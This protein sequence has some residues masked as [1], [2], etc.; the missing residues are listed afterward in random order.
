MLAPP[1]FMTSTSSMADACWAIPGSEKNFKVPASTVSVSGC[2]FNLLLS[3]ANFIG[4]PCVP[5]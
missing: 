2:C 3:N 5:T 4:L 1:V